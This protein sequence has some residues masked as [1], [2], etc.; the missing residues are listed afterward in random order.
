M[1]AVFEKEGVRY[2]YGVFFR[3]KNGAKEREVDFVLKNPVKPKR[4]DNGSVKY[5]EIKG[6]IGSAARKQHNELK[7][8]GVETFIVTEKLVEFYEKSGFL[9]ENIV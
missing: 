9:E 1:A 2:R 7:D 5:I 4:C 3:V 6:R 8:T